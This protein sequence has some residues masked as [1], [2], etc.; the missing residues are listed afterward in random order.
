MKLKYLLMIPADI[1]T[2]LFT[3]CVYWSKKIK[4][5]D[6]KTVGF[7]FLSKLRD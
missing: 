4:Q 7:R 1:S 3:G 6:F 5:D 2:L